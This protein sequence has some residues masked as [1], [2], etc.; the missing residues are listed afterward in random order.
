MRKK[1]ILLSPGVPAVALSNVASAIVSQGVRGTA[2]RIT[3][4]KI[5]LELTHG[6]VSFQRGAVPGGC[7]ITEQ[8]FEVQDETGNVRR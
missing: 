5:A 6:S 3:H 1:K 2:P 7:V 4:I 8:T